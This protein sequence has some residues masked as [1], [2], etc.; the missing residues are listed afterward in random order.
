[1][2]VTALLLLC[3]LSRAA[4]LR[5]NR[6][7]RAT[8]S[9]RA[10]NRLIE[11]GRLLV[12]G[13]AATS[14]DAR[15]GSG[16]S[17]ELDGRRILWE[18][19]DLG[20]HR[21]LKYHKP[22]GV[23]CTTSQSVANNIIAA[24]EAS[25]YDST[26]RRVYPIGRLDSDSSGLVLLTSD[27]AIVNPLLRAREGKRKEYE[28]VTTPRASDAD[29]QRLAA[30][31]DITT[32]AQRDGQPQLVTAPTAR[33]VVERCDRGDMLRF[34]L[35]EGRN[36]QIRRMCSALGLEVTAL[37]RVGFAGVAL[38]GIEVPGSWATLSEDEELAVGAR[39][40]PTRDELRTPEEKAR[41]RARKEARREAR[42][43]GQVEVDDG[44]LARGK[45]ALARSAARKKARQ[46]ATTK[47]RARRLRMCAVPPDASTFATP[48]RQ[49]RMALEVVNELTA[50]GMTKAAAIRLVKKNPGV[51]AAQ[52]D[53]QR[54]CNSD[55]DQGGHGVG[56][57]EERLARHA[58]PLVA[59]ASREAAS[60]ALC[61][62]GVVRIDHVLD[63]ATCATLKCHIAKLAA[64]ASDPESQRWAVWM[65][66]A[67][68][69][70]VPGSRVRLADTVV[71]VL[72]AERADVL[73]PLEDAVIADALR[74]AAT[75]VQTV[76]HGAISALPAH[77]AG[78]AGAGAD[79]DANPENIEIVECGALYARPGAEHQALHADYRRGNVLVTK[80]VGVGG[81]SNATPEKD[82]NQA[83]KPSMPPRLVCFVYLQDVPTHKHGPTVFL[84]GTA[85][86]ATHSQVFDIDGAVR[87]GSLEGREAER[88]ALC[89]AGD[90]VIYDASVL[91]YGS[92]NTVPGNERL[93]FYFGVSRAGHAQHCAGPPVEGWEASAPV[94]FWDYC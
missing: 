71:D 49:G 33:C 68:N 25:G 29:I 45:E 58:E 37:H 91:H 28:V 77:V 85:N 16:D 63:E 94:R 17:I 2:L 1:M 18:D 76:I 51:S 34:V 38:D 59:A 15:L 72:T 50:R 55:G 22:R 62:D 65:G 14:T 67:D 42:K 86:A 52:L 93:V 44:D 32:M 82:V 61:R 27:G 75:S 88:A 46:R 48:V 56:R 87:A 30:G 70:Y 57:I 80:G 21:Y 19:R 12:N 43:Q 20:S 26:A 74:T 6:A 8:H 69:R 39:A 41:R 3:P 60:E 23:E 66:A 11:E 9:R 35:E 13:V 64:A 54:T 36:R 24:L 89:S 92:A 40:L 53:P 5:V 73:L 79:A 90:A 4:S 83:V 31:I 78:H 47:P 10:C 7:L 81:T 84:P